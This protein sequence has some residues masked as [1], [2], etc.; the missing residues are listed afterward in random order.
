MDD[1]ERF[2]AL[3]LDYEI[4][5]QLVWRQLLQHPEVAERLLGT[6]SPSDMVWEPERGLFDLAVHDP[7]ETVYVEMKAGYGSLSASQIDRQR[8]FLDR[9]R[10]E[11]AE[12]RVAYALFGLS[13]FEHDADT[14]GEDTEGA[15]PQVLTYTNVAEAL[16]GAAPTLP[17]EDAALC[18][19]YQATLGRR[20]ERLLHDETSYVRRLRTYAT[21]R[22]LLPGIR[23]RVYRTSNASGPVVILND[24]LWPKIEVGAH[25]ARVYQ[26]VNNGRLSLKIAAGSLPDDS[27]RQLRRAVRR[28]AES[29]LGEAMPETRTSQV[30]RLGSYMTAL[31]VGDRSIDDLAPREAADLIRKVHRLL[32]DI[33][34]QVQEEA[35][36]WGA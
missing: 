13:T 14:L 29:V 31:V 21:I 25:E 17:R 8:A 5:H 11:G 24:R 1:L 27:K 36:R 32:S 10:Q 16:E 19:A 12:V 3:A 33:A 6:A 22:S 34:S 15:S 23:T 9:R 4:N 20:W 28:A 35:G 2:L 7:N 18:R 30:G 26:E